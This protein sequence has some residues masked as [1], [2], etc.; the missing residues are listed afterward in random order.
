VFS[1]FNDA[2]RTPD[3]VA[4]RDILK[5]LHAYAPLGGADRIWALTTT[6][7]EG[8]GKHKGN[9]LA[10]VVQLVLSLSEPK[11]RKTVK[12]ITV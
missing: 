9:H 4:E 6:L 11:S 2:G 12:K 3:R 8:A 10:A 1:S 7:L 5:V